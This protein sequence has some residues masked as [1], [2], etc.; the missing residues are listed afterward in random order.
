MDEKTGVVPSTE[1]KR[2]AKKTRWYDGETIST[3][4]GQGYMLTTPL[5]LASAYAAIANGGAIYTPQLVEELRN[6]QGELLEFFTPEKSGTVKV[7]TETLKIIKNALKGVTEEEGGTAYFLRASDLKIAGKTGTAQVSKLVKRTKD[8]N[9]IPYK[10]RDHAWFAGYAPYDSPK[11]A[12]VVLVEHGG[13]GA[14]AAAPV[15]RE[16]FKAYLGGSPEEGPEKTDQK[17][18]TAKTG[19]GSAAGV[20]TND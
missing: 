17:Q 3:A 6:P 19:A 20:N 18:I 7:S 5:Q 16:V 2:A 14:S 8:I 9:S 12:V 4:V 13:F 11:I 1:W 15:A 10:F